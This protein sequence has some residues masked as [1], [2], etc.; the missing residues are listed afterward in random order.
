MNMIINYCVYVPV[1][2][3]DSLTLYN[4]LQYTK[5]LMMTKGHEK[6]HIVDSIRNGN[7]NKRGGELLLL[8]V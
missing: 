7:I 2:V 6:K 8:L 4:L 5:L 3:R 1:S